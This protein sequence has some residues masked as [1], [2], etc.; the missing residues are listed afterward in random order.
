MA[1]RAFN[2]LKKKLHDCFQAFTSFISRKSLRIHENRKGYETQMKSS[3]QANN[4]SQSLVARR[5]KR[6]VLVILL[7]PT[8]ANKDRSELILLFL[9]LTSLHLYTFHLSLLISFSK[10]RSVTFVGFRT[11]R[12]REEVEHQTIEPI[13]EKFKFRF[14]LL[15]LRL[16]CCSLLLRSSIVLLYFDF[17]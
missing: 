15:M 5:P 14:Q 8:V 6:P 12:F 1:A 3:I 16:I 11:A 13:G 10:I 2:D 4:R 17:S 7:K 9:S